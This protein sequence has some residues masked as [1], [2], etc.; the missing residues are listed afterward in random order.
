MVAELKVPDETVG[1]LVAMVRR[2][3]NLLYSEALRPLG[4]TTRQ[5]GVLMRLW[6]EDGQT[7]DALVASLYT[8]QSSLSRVVDRMVKAGLVTRRPDRQDRRARRISLT[9]K[10]RALERQVKRIEDQ[11]ERRMLE[12]LSHAEIERIQGG[13][14]KLLANLAET[15]S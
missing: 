13:L 5:C 14:R 3:L 2:R 1:Y 12:G 8:D 4:V 9:Q 7:V 11:V 15:K 6:R 10:G